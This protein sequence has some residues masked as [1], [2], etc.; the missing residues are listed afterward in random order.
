MQQRPVQCVTVPGVLGKEG[1]ARDG[2]ALLSYGELQPE[3]EDDAGFGDVEVAPLFF[4]DGD[5]GVTADFDGV[6][7]GVFDGSGAGRNK[8]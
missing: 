6:G 1:P 3:D 4:V 8:P 5:V 7:V 2:P